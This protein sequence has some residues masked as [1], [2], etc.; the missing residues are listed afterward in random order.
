MSID[1]SGNKGPGQALHIMP[2]PVTPFTPE[3]RAPKIDPSAHVSPLCAVIG[4]VTVAGNVYIAPL[5]SIRAD[6]GFPFYIDSGTNLQDGAVLHGLAHGRVTHDGI[7]YSIYIG[8]NVSCAHGCIIHGPC[9]IGDNSFVGFH[10]TVYNASVGEGCFISHNAL[11]TGGVV[12]KPNS[13]VPPGIV[14]DSQ[15]K[16]D[17]LTQVTESQREF[18]EE[19][20]SVNHAFPGAYRKIGSQ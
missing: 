19:V 18:A 9:K 1:Q 14:V 2:N 10:A 17:S 7:E 3:S 15:E 4:D 8:K 5:V 6:E 12:L 16:A 13:F 11:V 20:Q